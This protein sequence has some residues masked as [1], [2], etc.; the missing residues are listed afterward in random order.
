MTSATGAGARA[1]AESNAV[2]I[3]MMTFGSMGDEQRIVRMSRSGSI[4]G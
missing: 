4:R 1:A 2:I 3:Y